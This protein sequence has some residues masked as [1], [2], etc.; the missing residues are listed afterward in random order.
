MTIKDL[1]AKTGYSIGTV[2]RVLNNQPHVSVKARQTILRA[3][4]EMGFQLNTNAQQLKQSHSTAVLVIVK[5]RTNELFGDLVQF[6]HLRVKQTS[7]PL[8]VDYVDENENEVLRAIRL[9]AAKKPAAVLFLGGNRG[10]FLKDFHRIS[11]P[12]TLITNS[13]EYLPFDNL[14]SVSCDDV[15]AARMAIDHLAGLGHRKIVV[16]GGNRDAS[17]VAALRYQGCMEAFRE[18]GIA[19][20]DE[21]DYEQARFSYAD[22]YRAAKALLDRG[23]EFT[24]LFA[25]SDVMAIGAIRA[26][27]DA[28]KRVPEDISVLGF[29]GLSM[30]EY[31]VPRLSTVSQ[32]GGELVSKSLDLLDRV[33]WEKTT[34]H[35]TVP[36]TL[37]W[38]ESTRE[39]H[40]D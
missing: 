14:S 21:R 24:A 26:L 29:D 37:K 18:H 38:R 22:G 17:D 28:G 30:G 39:R 20:E 12:C 9:C 35:I 13:A 19:F 33:Y 10:N 7:Y 2:S 4:E 32:A 34:D 11:L 8:I 6:L 16:I 40:D 1:A 31:T 3:C 25:M 36:V 23:E 27:Q 15:K 5:G